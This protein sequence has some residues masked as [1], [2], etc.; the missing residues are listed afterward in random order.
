MPK[1]PT[2]VTPFESRRQR[3]LGIEPSCSIHHV[4]SFSV[5][6]LSF[7]HSGLNNVDAVVQPGNGIGDCSLTLLD[8]VRGIDEMR[9]M[10]LRYMLDYPQHIHSIPVIQ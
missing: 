8:L 7:K 6:T 2:Y 1:I 10:D 9:L 5:P 3:T 4:P